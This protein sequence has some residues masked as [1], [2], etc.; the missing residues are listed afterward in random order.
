MG[1]FAEL[2]QAHVEFGTTKSHK[3][4][5]GKRRKRAEDAVGPSD[6]AVPRPKKKPRDSDASEPDGDGVASGSG[7]GAT[8]NSS[9]GAGAPR[10]RAS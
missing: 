1:A 5:V 4:L 9:S 3:K 2:W 8:G 7:T 6:A 10:P